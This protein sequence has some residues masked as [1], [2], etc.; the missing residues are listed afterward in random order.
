MALPKQGGGV[1]EDL[2]GGV[3]MCHETLYVGARRD[4]PGLGWHG[5]SVAKIRYGR[6]PAW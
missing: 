2:E 5:P 4:R 1:V 3:V 6:S